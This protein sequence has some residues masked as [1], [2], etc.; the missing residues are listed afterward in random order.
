MRLIWI[1]IILYLHRKDTSR[2]IG[3]QPHNCWH[4][5]FFNRYVLNHVR[6]ICSIYFLTLRY[7]SYRHKSNIERMYIYIYNFALVPWDQ[8]T[9]F[10]VAPEGR[11]PG[12]S[13]LGRHNIFGSISQCQIVTVTVT[14]NTLGTRW[15]EMCYTR[16]ALRG[17]GWA[18]V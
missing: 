15:H 14:P 1:V 12:C 17:D 7:Y 4:T 9:I 3:N 16:L 6:L 8:V 18:R 10:M 5:S 2:P 13:M 11:A